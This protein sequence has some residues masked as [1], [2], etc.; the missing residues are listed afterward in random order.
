[1]HLDVSYEEL[2]ERIVSHRV[3]RFI[4]GQEQLL[5]DSDTASD[6]DTASGQHYMS[7]TMSGPILDEN[8]VQT[9]NLLL[10]H[11]SQSYSTTAS[12]TVVN[13]KTQNVSRGVCVRR[14]C[15]T[16]GE[17]KVMLQVI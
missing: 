14:I 4:E 3:R 10:V 15:T 17:V 7:R 9:L 12:H 1:M 6:A 8:Q 16:A 2:D 13:R 11:C 5:L